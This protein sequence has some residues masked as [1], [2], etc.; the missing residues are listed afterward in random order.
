MGEI[1]PILLLAKGSVIAE[2]C[3]MPGTLPVNALA[4][5]VPYAVHNS[6]GGICHRR[7]TLRA[8]EITVKPPTRR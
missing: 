8:H 5:E 1:G 4:A 3:A 2:G 6:S 7:L